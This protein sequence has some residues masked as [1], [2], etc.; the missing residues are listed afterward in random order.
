MTV[1]ALKIV[2]RLPAGIRAAGVDNAAVVKLGDENQ[3]ALLTNSD[4]FPGPG[5]FALVSLFFE[6]DSNKKV[7]LRGP[8]G[9]Q[10]T[11]EL[12][13]GQGGD[14]A[15]EFQAKQHKVFEDEAEFEGFWKGLLRFSRVRWEVVELSEST[16]AEY[17]A[18][19]DKAIAAANVKETNGVNLHEEL[20]PADAPD[21]SERPAG[22]F[23]PFSEG[24]LHDLR[25]MKKRT[26]KWNY[27]QLPDNHT[28]KQVYWRELELRRLN[29][30]QHE[31]NRQANLAR[32]QQ[33]TAAA[34]TN[35]LKR[36]R[37]D[38]VAAP[39]GTAPAQTE[40]SSPAKKARKPK[41]K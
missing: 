2:A 37:E 34:A 14:F 22:F 4:V 25:K 20:T 39:E 36:K 38:K 13:S 18:A 10:Q 28:Y 27:E 35:E 9:A 3:G 40:E 19:E 23:Q 33:R 16:E 21:S 41:S 32:A 6:E 26:V 1:N 11:V 17:K 31:K 24:F 7:T 12:A 15:Y 8:V 5:A 29:A 30:I